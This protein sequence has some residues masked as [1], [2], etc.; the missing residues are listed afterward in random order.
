MS[1]DV[2]ELGLP[3]VKL[4][5]PKKFGDARGFFSETFSARVFAEAGIG[6]PFVQ[7]NHSHSAER[8]TVRGLHFQAPPHAQGKLLR[9]VRGAVLDVVLDIR[10]GSPT[11]GR[12]VSAELSADNWAQIWVPIGL[13]HGFCTLVPDT[14]VIYKVTH[15]YAPQSEM[16]VFW[17]DPA[18]G[19][20][21]PDFAG[22]QISGKDAGLPL[23]RDFKSPFT[24]GT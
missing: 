9:V 2:H 1:P 10:V 11:Y 4:V 7:D 14:Q 12:H 24:F 18:L 8:G 20:D 6:G 21:W 15:Y 3:G 17:R 16:G 5:T 19:I 22:A 13:V 23:F